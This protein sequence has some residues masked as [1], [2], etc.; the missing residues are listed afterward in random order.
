MTGMDHRALQELFSAYLEGDLSPEEQ[1]QV[2]SHLESCEEC[3]R[4]LASFQRTLRG[5]SSLR[6]VPPP[7]G[8]SRKV[9]QRIHRRSR[10]RFFKTERL[11]MRV[12]FEWISFIIIIIM[13][14]LYMLM[15]EQQRKLAPA[16]GSGTGNR[17]G[18]G[19]VAPAPKR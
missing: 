3:R 6:A 2:S 5:L 18:V 1:T 9:Q 4:E 10:G 15:M 19:S 11:L 14:V 8:F 17:P 16:K 13:L 7:E 12:P